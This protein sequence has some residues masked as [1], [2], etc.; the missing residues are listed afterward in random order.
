[1]GKP[2]PELHLRNHGAP[3]RRGMSPPR[4]LS[5]DH[6]HR[7]QLADDAA[8]SVYGDCSAVS[9]QWLEPYMDDA[10]FR[11]HAGLLPRHHSQ[12]DL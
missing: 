10:T 1:M 9:L 12:R 2:L 5:D 8:P 6:G 4:R 11:R 3:E 7:G